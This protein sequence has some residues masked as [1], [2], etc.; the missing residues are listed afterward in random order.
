MARLREGSSTESPAGA[1]PLSQFSREAGNVG[2]CVWDPPNFLLLHRVAHSSPPSVLNPAVDHVW[3][4][5]VSACEIEIDLIVPR[6]F[7]SFKGPDQPLSHQE[8]S[9]DAM[10]ASGT[11]ERGLLLP[12]HPETSS[13]APRAAKTQAQRG[14]EMYFAWQSGQGMGTSYMTH[15]RVQMEKPR[16]KRKA[17]R[18]FLT[19]TCRS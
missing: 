4:P 11:P 15:L 12:P 7:I 18:I 10:V 1:A 9:P 2:F 14:R 17:G 16:P 5:L 6:N 3:W 8:P 19:P 13:N